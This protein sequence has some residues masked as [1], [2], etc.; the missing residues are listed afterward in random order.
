M[1]SV[2]AVV[3]FGVVAV[4]NAVHNGGNG[5]M[6][7]IVRFSG[8][9]THPFLIHCRHPQSTSI[10]AVMKAPRTT[11]S[12]MGFG[13]TVTRPSAPMVTRGA[14]IPRRSATCWPPRRSMARTHRMPFARGET[15]RHLAP[16]LPRRTR[17][18]RARRPNRSQFHPLRGHGRRRAAHVRV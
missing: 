16:P 2:V 14:A 4:V 9:E 5:K 8:H 1:R 15:V 17:A 18:N 3:A 10:V 11:G 7:Q 6:Q 12:G 13:R